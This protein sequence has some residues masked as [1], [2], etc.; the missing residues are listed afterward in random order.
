MPIRFLID[1]QPCLGLDIELDHERS[2]YL[3]KVL[4]HKRGDTVAC[5]D[6][7]GTAFD[8]E[9]LEAHSKQSVLRV[10]SVAPT[11]APAA[12]HLTLGLGLLKGQAMDRAL[13]QATELGAAAISLLVTERSNVSLPADRAANK[14]AHWQKI[15]A[16][17]CEQ[18]GH[19]Y[20]PEVSLQQDVSSLL[21]AHQAEV[22]VLD[23]GGAPLPQTLAA[24]DRLLLIGPE[25]GWSDNERALFER[26]NNQCYRLTDSTLRAETAPAVALALFKHL[27]RG[28]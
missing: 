13:Q 15:V 18:S 14:L 26:Q 2:H 12:P 11:A 20:V 28:A 23:M 5:F 1:A 8:A 24:C 17:A 21:A 9:L 7:R 6:G 25:G 10:A 27:M 16:G 19:L 22:A 4:R 3:C